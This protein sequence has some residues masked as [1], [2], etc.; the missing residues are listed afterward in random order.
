MKKL[1]VGLS[2]IFELLFY[3]FF[4]VLIGSIEINNGL[5]AF[6]VHI[7][8]SLVIALSFY[9]LIRFIFIKLDM[10]AKLYIYYLAVCNIIIGGILPVF[11]IIIIPSEVLTNFAFIILVCTIYYGILINIFLCL[12]NAVLTNRQKLK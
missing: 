11:L 4:M 12:L 1:V 8:A 10:R 2:A 9:Y 5:L 3:T 6:L 7:L